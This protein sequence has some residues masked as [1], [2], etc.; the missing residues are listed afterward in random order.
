MQIRRG[1]IFFANLDPVIGSE[2]GGN[3]PVLIIQNDVGNLHSSTV[4]IVPLTSR[5]KKR[6]STHVSITLNGC[7]NVVLGEQMRT[8]SKSRLR[9]RVGRLNKYDMSKVNYA[10]QGTGTSA[11]LK[12]GTS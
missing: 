10:I 2:Q 12:F 3:R 5:I 4:I 6:M 1:D 8:I 9:D 7:P 11:S